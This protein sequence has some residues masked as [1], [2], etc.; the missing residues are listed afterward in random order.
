MG[1]KIGT[2]RHTHYSGLAKH[3]FRFIIRMRK[4]LSGHLFSIVLRPV[5]PTFDNLPW[6]ISH[7]LKVSIDSLVQWL[8]LWI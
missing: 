4:V 6:Q 2:Y 1:G 7:S 5:T 8:G 3:R